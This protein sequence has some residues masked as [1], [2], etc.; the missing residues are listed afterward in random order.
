[1]CM[2]GS[3]YMTNRNRSSLVISALTSSS[4][5]FG[6]VRNTTK[7]PALDNVPGGTFQI[8]A[9]MIGVLTALT[10]LGRA[11]GLSMNFGGDMEGKKLLMQLEPGAGDE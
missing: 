8:G 3:P 11:Q 4:G 9:G 10:G 1:M 7:R 6:G 5:P 2:T